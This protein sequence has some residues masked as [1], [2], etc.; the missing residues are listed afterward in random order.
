MSYRGAIFDVDGVLV[1][2]PHERAWRETLQ[3]LVETNWRSVQP[4]RTYGSERYTLVVYQE[5]VAG[6]PRMSG[7][8]A[9]LDDVFLD[10][11][12]GGPLERRSG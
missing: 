1:D 3:L 11:L 12:A 10:A 2:S 6:K 7:A 9:A 8:R 5:V 4:R